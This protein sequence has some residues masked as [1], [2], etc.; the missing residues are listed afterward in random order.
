[1]SWIGNRDFLI[2]QDFA[3]R[4]GITLISDPTSINLYD[5]Q[6]LLMHGDSLCVA[7]K[8]HQR[9]RKIIH[10]KIV[11]TI[12]LMLPLSYRKKIAEQLRKKSQQGN[13]YKMPEIMD[14]CDDAVINII[15]KFNVEKIIHGH[16]HRPQ[17]L[18][19]IIVLN[20]WHAQGNYLQI[21]RNWNVALVDIPR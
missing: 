3:D 19:N 13:R 21:D 15:Q 20:A 14:V 6:I 12:F 4:A 11:Q 7:D 8:N 18:D 17:I 16:T 1:M 9:F 10:N 2:G 5:R